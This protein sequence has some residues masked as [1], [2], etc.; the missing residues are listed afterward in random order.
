MNKIVQLFL[1]HL[2]LVLTSLFVCLLRGICFL[3]LFV[4]T[5]VPEICFDVVMK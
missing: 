1:E 2:I 5:L 4:L 3:W